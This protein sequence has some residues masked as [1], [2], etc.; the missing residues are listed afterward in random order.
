MVEKSIIEFRVICGSTATEFQD[1][2]NATMEDL[3]KE[4][5][6]NVRYEFNHNREQSKWREWNC[7]DFR[8]ANFYL[9]S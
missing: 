7:T 5:A 1:N 8:D 9:G 4:N 3:A 6:K 2:L